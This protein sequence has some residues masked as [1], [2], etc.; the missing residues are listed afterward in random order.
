VLFLNHFSLCETFL[1][2]AVKNIQ[3]FWLTLI[4]PIGIN[5]AKTRTR[6]N[7]QFHNQ[8]AALVLFLNPFFLCETFLTYAVKKHPIVLA[9]PYFPDWH[10]FGQN[11]DMQKFSILQSKCSSGAIS[12]SFFSLRNLSSLCGKKT[13]NRFGESLFSQ[14]ASIRPKPGHI[15]ILIL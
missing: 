7:S 11:L 3:P 4:F 15:K 14:L 13:S 2:Y 6:K 10:L 12:K 9:N 5:S 1:P 8:N